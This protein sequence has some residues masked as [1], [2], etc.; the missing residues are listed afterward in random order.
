MIAPLF[1]TWR[2]TNRYG[3]EWEFVYDSK[4]GEGILRG[5]DVGR[6]LVS[7]TRCR[8]R[9]EED[10]NN[11]RGP[12]RRVLFCGITGHGKGRGEKPKTYQ[13]DDSTHKMV[14]DAGRAQRSA[15]P[16]WPAAD[17]QYV[18]A[19]GD[20]LPLAGVRLGRCTLR[21]RFR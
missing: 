20:L 3:E 13:G 21:P 18:K 15:D 7:E 8:F 12:G 16:R 10:V 4:T 2:F 11:N 1:P 19:A 14:H 5:S 6:R 9:S 17:Y